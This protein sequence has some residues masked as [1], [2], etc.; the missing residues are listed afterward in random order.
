MA[1]LVAMY[2]PPGEMGVNQRPDQYP[3]LN[4]NPTLLDKILHP[5]NLKL[6]WKQVK[7]NKGAPGIDNVTIDKFPAINRADWKDFQ[8]LIEA[9]NYQPSPV[10]RVYIEKDDG[11]Q[12]NIGIPIVRDRV[13]QQAIIQVLSPLY[14]EHFSDYSFGF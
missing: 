11:S 14:D 5:E 2:S 13:I 7:A 3:A 10:K 8:S 4:E 1:D 12:R 6:A 9:G